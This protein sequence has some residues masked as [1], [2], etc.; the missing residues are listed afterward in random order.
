MFINLAIALLQGNLWVNV[1]SNTA[2][3]LNI[4]YTTLDECVF[5]CVS[6]ACQNAEEFL[7]FPPHS[8]QESSILTKTCDC[9][10]STSPSS[11]FYSSHTIHMSPLFFFPASGPQQDDYF[12]I[13]H[14][15]TPCKTHEREKQSKKDKRERHRRWI[16]INSFKTKKTIWLSALSLREWATKFRASRQRNLKAKLFKWSN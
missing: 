1:W 8:W 14:S 11:P 16:L 10:L 13:N 4:Y 7:W 12:N 3:S 15:H 9:S 6:C 2:Q 5:V